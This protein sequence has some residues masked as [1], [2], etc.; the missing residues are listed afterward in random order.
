MSNEI[1]DQKRQKFIDLLKQY[2]QS[3]NNDHLKNKHIHKMPQ[4]KEE[5]HG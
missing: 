5:K 2:Q 3:K 1:L 4:L